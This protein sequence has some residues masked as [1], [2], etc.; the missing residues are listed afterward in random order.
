MSDDEISRLKFFLTQQLC[1]M[2][3]LEKRI[4]ALEVDTS[5]TNQVVDVLVAKIRK[6]ES[7][8]D[9]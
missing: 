1:L 6:M 3:N 9:G 5:I 8:Y 4:K 7:D 2:G